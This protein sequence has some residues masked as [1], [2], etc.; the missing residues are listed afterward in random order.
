MN[1]RNQIMAAT[2]RTAAQSGWTESR[3]VSYMRKRGATSSDIESAK[4]LYHKHRNGAVAGEV[5]Q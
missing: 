3:L 5:S 1:I 2:G 4:R